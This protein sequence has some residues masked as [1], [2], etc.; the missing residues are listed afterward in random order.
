MYLKASKAKATVG[1]LI[2]ETLEM[3]SELPRGR[4]GLF[5][6]SSNSKVIVSYVFPLFMVE[7][8]KARDKLLYVLGYQ[9]CRS[10]GLSVPQNIKN[11]RNL[12]EGN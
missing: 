2:K 11:L 3:R 10:L 1:L 7:S 8:M 4:T 12:L 9:G 6:P 5:I